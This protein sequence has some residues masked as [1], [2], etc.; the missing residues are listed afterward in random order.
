MITIVFLTLLGASLPYLIYWFYSRAVAVLSTPVNRIHALYFILAAL[1]ISLIIDIA[2]VIESHFYRRFWY[3]M[4]ARFNWLYFGKKSALSINTLENPEFRD[5]VTK[6][7]ENLIFPL[8]TLYLVR[9]D[10]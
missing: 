10:D 9:F 7:Q 6:A 1:I 3:A 5:T 4:E 2:G 8:L